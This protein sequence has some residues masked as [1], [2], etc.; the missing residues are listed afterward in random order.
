LEEVKYKESTYKYLITIIDCFTKYAWVKA[1][2]DR[3]AATIVEFISTL[4]PV[5]GIPHIIQSDNGVEFT[6]KVFNDYVESLNVEAKKND[7]SCIHITSRPY[8][9]QSQGQC[10]R[11]NGTFKKTIQACI[12]KKSNMG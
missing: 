3:T 12:R 2:T 11:F 8:H 10:E 9:P 5:N 6:A 4:F 7:S 1:V